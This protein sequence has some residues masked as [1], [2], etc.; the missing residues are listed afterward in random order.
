MH[1]TPASPPLAQTRGI[2]KGKKASLF[3]PSSLGLEWLKLQI[4]KK[5]AEE[6]SP[7]LGMEI[8]INNNNL[9]RVI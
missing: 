2:S 7:F 1:S 5:S 9:F 6:S 3:S 4:T 8:I